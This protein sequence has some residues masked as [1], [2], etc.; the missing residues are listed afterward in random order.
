MLELAPAA[1]GRGITMKKIADFIREN[2]IEHDWRGNCFYIWA[3]YID[4]ETL[5][6]FEPKEVEKYFPRKEA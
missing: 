2:Y 4:M 3:I 1:S 6:V 5:K